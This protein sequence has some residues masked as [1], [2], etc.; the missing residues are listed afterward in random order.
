MVPSS[1]PFSD[2][3][4]PVAA[5]GQTVVEVRASAINYV[6]ILVRQGRYPQMPPLPWIPGGEIAGVA[7][8]RRVLALG[9]GEAGG[10]AE[11]VAVPDALL[12]DL[13]DEASFEEG[14]SF[15]LSFLT[16]WIP[17]TRQAHVEAGV[18]RCS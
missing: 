5:D 4:E 9:A 11:R 10:Y 17:L 13:P 15:L 14:A 3:P 7:G 8:E 18:A 1:C 6:E 12:F 16:A 2:V